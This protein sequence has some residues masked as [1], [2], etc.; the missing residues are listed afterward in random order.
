MIKVGFLKDDPIILAALALKIAQTPFEEGTIAELYEDCRKDRKKSKDF[1]N[2]IMQKNRHLIPGD[3]CGHAITL[4][5]LSRFAAIYLWR[6]VSAPNLIFGAGI[7]AS[8]RV[9]SP[10]RYIKKI[11][12]FGEKT[13]ELYEKALALEVPKQDAKCILPEGALTRMIFSAPPRYLLK[14]ADY[15]KELPIAELNKIGSTTRSL[16]EQELEFE[17]S[18]EKVPSR[19][20][21]WGDGNFTE[22]L[23]LRHRDTIHS[24]D[25]DM[26]IKGSLSMFADLVRQRQ[27]LCQ[28]EPLEGIAQK[29]RFVLP[30]SFPKEMIEDYKDIASKARAEQIKLIEKKDPTFVYFL[31]LGQEAA[32]RI[33][34]KGAGVIESAKARVEGVVYPE[35][36]SNF[37]I[38][39]TRELAKYPELKKQIGPLCWR[40]G[41][42]IEPSTL[43]TR[44]NVCKIF[45]E[46]KHE[47]EKIPTERTLGELLQMLDE[48]Y[49]TFTI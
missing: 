10:N 8:F 41:K 18:K 12:V 14:L 9:I 33:Y 5:N 20:K 34:V 25:L 39:L 44:K 15:L 2:G 4:E 32:A 24:F 37:S 3:F 31:L 27:Q 13:F 22:E 26:T 17:I 11:G 38:P 7:E 29:S 23:K 36:R 49:G 30:P 16:V 46:L 40:E 21:L 47:L 1:A 19:W 43:K 42:C 35:L 45:D 6:A 28:I 48:P